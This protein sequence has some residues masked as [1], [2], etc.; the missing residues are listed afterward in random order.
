MDIGRSIVLRP[1]MS[2]VLNKKKKIVSTGGISMQELIAKYEEILR[3]IKH[4]L[5]EGELKPGDRI[6]SE[7]QLCTQFQVS[8]Q[9]VRHAISLL[10]NE[11]VVERRRGSGTYVKAAVNVQDKE[12][13]TMQVAVMTTFVQEY[14]FSSIIQEIEHALSRS[15]YGMQL[16]FTNNSVEK[17]RFILKNILEKNMVDGLIAETTKSGLPN[18][19]LDIYKKIMN[20]GIP[21]IFI[22]SHYPGLNAP[23]VSLDD[24]MAGKIAT[25]HLIKCGHRNIAAIFKADDGQGHKRYA[26]Y[27]EALMEADIRIKGEHII[28]IDTEDVRHMREDSSWILR[29]LQGCSACVC[30]NDEVASNLVAVCLEQNIRVPEELSVVG[31]DDS[32]MANFCEVPLT[33]VRNPIRDLGKIAALEML[34]LMEGLAVPK[35]TELDPEIVNRNSVKIIDSI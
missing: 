19:N 29:R 27:I 7:H 13:K 16:S 1:D 23:Y 4:R 9:T 32:E 25:N 31:I 34:E 26:G 30:Y 12:K 17:E 24:K 10:E 15:G 35:N 18:P 14:I 2:K 5:E 21:V 3:W 28:W 22:N 11:G 6:E 33:S 20:K 8:R